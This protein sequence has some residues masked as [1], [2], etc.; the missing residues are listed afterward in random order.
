MKKSNLKIAAI[1]ISAVMAVLLL[2]IAV[3]II[4]MF[5]VERNGIGIIGGSGL[6]S[7]FFMLS[8]FKMEWKVLSVLAIFLAYVL[9]WSWEEEKQNVQQ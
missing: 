2:R 4:F 8:G 7:L 9:L 5:A 6:P 3:D 1:V